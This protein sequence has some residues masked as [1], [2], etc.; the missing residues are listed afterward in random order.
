MKQYGKV[1]AREGEMA[2]VAVKGMLRAR[3]AGRAVSGNGRTSW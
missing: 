3:S 2:T 1:I